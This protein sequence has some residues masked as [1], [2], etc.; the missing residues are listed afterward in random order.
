M[1]NSRL[2]VSIAAAFLVLLAVSITALGH[3]PVK[4][5]P[6]EYEMDKIIIPVSINGSKAIRCILDTGMVEGVFLMDPAAAKE[7]NLKYAATNVML[8][9]GGSGTATASMAMGASF[10]LEDISFENQRVIV[11]NEAGPLA[12]AGVVG[13]VG[14]SIFNRFVVQIDI[15]KK[16]LRL[17]KP[18]EFDSKDAGESFELTLT[19]TKP[20]MNAFIDIDGKKDLPVTLV[21][22]TGAN[23][24]LMFTVNK[25]KGIVTPS[26]SVDG[27]IGRGV[28][29]EVRGKAARSKKLALGK[30]KL[31][32]TIA[33]FYTDGIPGGTDGVIGMGILER[34]LVTFDYAGKRMFLKPNEDFTKP[35]EFSMIGMSVLPDKDGALSIQSV[36]DGSPA[37]E[38]GIKKG[39]ILISIDKKPLSFADYARLV[40]ALIT[41]GQKIMIEIER[42]GVRHEKSLELKRMI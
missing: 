12:R 34:F 18:D 40:Q 5:I 10:T 39:D 11:I 7:L 42:N 28:G 17:Y 35:F 14:A 41:P 9:G 3:S 23:S 4:E 22:D 29:G 21:I 32:D 26:K 33:H 25:E 38:A 2:I 24:T 19:R 13:V 36:F 15:E 30:Y 16:I 20:Y 6:F 37:L 31:L 1:R 8:R 27:V